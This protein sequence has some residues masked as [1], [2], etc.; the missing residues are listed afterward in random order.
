MQVNFGSFKPRRS[1][2]YSRM[3]L[4]LD[5]DEQAR[6]SFVDPAPAMV[7]VH[8]FEKVVVGED[9]KPIEE[10][11]KWPDGSPR[12][13]Y[14][15]EYAGKFRCLGEDEPLERD[16][17]DPEN[18]PACRAH[19][20]HSNAIKAPSVRILGY[21]IKYSTKP[22]TW[23]LTKPF[24]AELKVWDL[25]EKRFE[26]LN[27]IYEEH[28]DLS[29]KDLLLGPCELKQMQK[30]GIQVG[31][32]T[33]EYT[34]NPE[35]E[36]YVYE[37]LKEGQLDDIADVAGKRPSAFEMETKVK[38]IVRDYNHAFGVQQANYYESL[39]NEPVQVAAQVAAPAPVAAPAEVVEEVINTETGEVT[40]QKI[41]QPKGGVQSIQDLLA[42]I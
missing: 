10:H 31:G 30:Y 19:I 17:V 20:E 12:V 37:L 29:K 32:G 14:K 26:T 42:S 7:F 41:E 34:H 5:K 35:Q 8:S 18:C 27:G 39:I 15:T 16:G 36:Q 33:A 3:K 25:T 21:V 22:G 24:G 6:V 1:A 23:S 28:G 40:E 11:G 38:E 9:G 13:S 2:N 4:M